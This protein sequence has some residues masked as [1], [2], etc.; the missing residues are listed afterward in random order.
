MEQGIADEIDQGSEGEDIFQTAF[1][2]AEDF[3]SIGI[4]RLL[5]PR[6]IIANLHIEVDQDAIVR[7]RF[8]SGGLTPPA[9]HFRCC[10]ELFSDLFRPR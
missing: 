5:L 10:V 1:A 4:R 2:M 7:N 9:R 3:Q 6:K 8:H